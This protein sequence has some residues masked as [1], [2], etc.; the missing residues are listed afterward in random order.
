MCNNLISGGIIKICDQI[1]DETSYIFNQCP[2]IMEEQ[3]V[4]LR[5]RGRQKMN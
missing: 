4:L 2:P 3:Y 5:K 1:I